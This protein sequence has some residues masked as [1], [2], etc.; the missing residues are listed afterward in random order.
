[1]SE[2]C[3]EPGKCSVRFFDWYA[4]TLLEVDLESL[5]ESTNLY[6]GF[7][8]DTVN[9]SD[10]TRMAPESDL[11]PRLRFSTNRRVQLLRFRRPPNGSAPRSLRSKARDHGP[12]RARQRARYGPT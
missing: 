7:A 5:V 9:N 11:A 4:E 6:D 2:V 8:N 10:P 3:T 1:L 12:R